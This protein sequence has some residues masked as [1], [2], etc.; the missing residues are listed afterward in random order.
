MPDQPTALEYALLGLLL[1]QP[2]S[3]YQLRRTFAA[4]PMGHH[5]DSPGSIY[6]A[7]KRMTRRGWIKPAPPS[8]AANGRGTQVLAP[9]QRG[10]AAMSA[11]C[12][13]PIERH[14]VMHAM[15]SLWL[16]FVYAAA[17]LDV[18]E[19]RA[20]IERLRNAVREYLTELRA[21]Y[22]QHAKSL[23]P[24]GQ[25]ALSAGIAIYETQARVIDRARRHYS[26]EGS[27]P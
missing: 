3:G 19:L 10:R 26:K 1:Q 4:T 9:T 12:R 21:Y 24:A 15:E 8:P 22:R 7:L 17:L 13:R 27:K 18:T 14:E 23:P 5:S 16:R 6:P 25:I 2:A 20:F 11:L